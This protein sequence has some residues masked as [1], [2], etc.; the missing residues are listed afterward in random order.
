M[1]YEIA[2]R[3]RRQTKTFGK[4]PEPVFPNFTHDLESL[5]WIAL[6]TISKRIFNPK[7]PLVKGVFSHQVDSI[8]PGRMGVFLLD[9]DFTDFFSEDILPAF[10]ELYNPFDTTRKMLLME[11]K[12]S[13]AILRDNIPTVPLDNLMKLLEQATNL[14]VSK[15]IKLLTFSATRVSSP[16]SSLQ[17]A[18]LMD[19]SA[20][21]DSPGDPGPSHLK[22]RLCFLLLF[23]RHAC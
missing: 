2:T 12:K 8:T 16:T 15:P 9:D 21:P 20:V 18:P 5:W 23:K 1:A 11:Y 19:K 17:E 22:R 14:A 3:T 13:N 7:A 10:A 6:W 4:K